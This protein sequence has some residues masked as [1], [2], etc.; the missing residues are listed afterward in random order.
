MDEV[1]NVS[2]CPGCGG[3]DLYRTVRPVAAG[4]GHAPNYLP[5]LG[6]WWR[7]ERFV[8]VLCKSCGLTRFFARPEATAK[9]SESEKWERA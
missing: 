5:G 2:P 4:G 8:L 6:P 9:V 3:S 1:M 7:S